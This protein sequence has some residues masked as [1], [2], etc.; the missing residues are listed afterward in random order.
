MQ[1][2]PG[3]GPIL[4]A[5]FVAEIGDVTRFATPAHLSS[6][7]GLTPKHRE[8][9]TVVHRGPIT[10]NLANTTNPIPGTATTLVAELRMPQRNLPPPQQKASKPPA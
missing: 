6:W 3:V 10:K 2:V 5:I 8:S 7:P 4:A 1:Q 9:D